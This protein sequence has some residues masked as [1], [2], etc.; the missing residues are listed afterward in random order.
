MRKLLMIVPLILAGACSAIAQTNQVQASG[1]RGQRNF[2]VAAFESVALQGPHNVVVTVGNGP[3]V[4]AEGDTAALDMLDIRVENGRLIVGT[5]RGWSWNGPDGA[6]T[7]H[8]ST[9]ALNGAAIGG[10]GDMRIDR[11]QGDRFAASVSGSGD[12]EIGAL[13]IREAGFSIAG[14]GDIRAVGSAEATDISI[15]GSGGMALDG[16]QARR[17][18]VSIMGS[19]DVTIQASEA[20]EGSIMGSGNINVRG[21]ARCNVTRMGSGSVNCGRSSGMTAD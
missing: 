3:S 6:V 13:Q 1:Q 12:M 21:D 14:S 11:V 5:R 8:V 20:V 2:E 19:G 15:A 16:L 9:R 17:A 18:N 7:V 4:R 10:S